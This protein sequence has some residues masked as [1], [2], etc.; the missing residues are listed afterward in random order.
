MSRH[1]KTKITTNGLILAL[2]AGN[3][4]SYTG[5]Q[6]NWSDL[7]GLNN[8]VQFINSPTFDSANAGSI[9]LDGNSYISISDADP[10]DHPT[11]TFTGWLNFTSS[12]L[13][14]NRILSKKIS[15]ADSDG[16]EIYLSTG[17][18]TNIN[19]S[20]A[21]SLAASIS[22]INWVGTGWHHLVVT[23]SGTTVSV[24]VDGNYYGQGTINSTIPN[25]RP[26]HIGKLLLEA[27]QWVGKISN[28]SMYNRVLS[29]QEISNN[30]YAL[31]SRYIYPHQQ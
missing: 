2:D 7:S 25:G 9:V 21:G 17:T 24:Y 23:Y 8:T 31:L 19:I 16:Y 28:V 15:S 22:T 4:K 10:F 5:L 30:Y 13:N 20:G 3:Y 29:Q 12:S 6:N 26:L 1:W 11:F 27:T 14:Y 18:D